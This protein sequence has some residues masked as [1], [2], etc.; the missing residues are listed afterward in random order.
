MHYAFLKDNGIQQK[1]DSSIRPAASSE[2]QTSERKGNSKCEANYGLAITH[3][4]FV[5]VFRYW[6]LLAQGSV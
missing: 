2:H 1:L 3:E 6:M 4:G 5:T